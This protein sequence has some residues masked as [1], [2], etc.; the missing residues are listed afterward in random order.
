M[1]RK[2]PVTLI[3][4]RRPEQLRLV[5]EAVRAYRPDTIFAVSDGAK[6][7]DSLGQDRVRGCRA[8]VQQVVDWPCQVERIF[9]ETNLGLRGR[10][11]SGLNEVFQ[12]TDFSV[13]L[14][15]DCVPLPEFFPFVE[16]VRS[17]WETEEQVGAISGNSFLPANLQPT[18]SYFFSR[19]P[20]I[21]GWA[22]W[23]RC[24]RKHNSGDTVWPVKGGL[25]SLWPDMD[26]REKDYWERIFNRVYRHE[27]ETWDYRWL[28]S[29]WRNHWLAVTP[30]ENLVQN[31]G[32]G[33]GATNTRDRSVDPGVE[34]TGRM[35]F[36][37][38]HPDEIRRDEAA[39]QA[40]FRNHYLRMEG[41]LSFWPRLIR[42]LGKRLLR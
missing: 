23:A 3:F 38:S 26:K 17:R 32:F 8:L 39:D 35:S 41:R 25:G 21:W 9:A 2:L 10:V 1:S 4:Y 19:Y 15:E 33:E 29:F 20:H 7:G 14:E 42:S 30:R 24:W 6:A 5:L 36:A 31:T 13:I 11:E 28:F 27:L 12:K 40:V 34:R 22:T 18:H 16:E 37:L